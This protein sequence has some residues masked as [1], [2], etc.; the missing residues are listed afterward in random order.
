MGV[1]F[2]IL[3]L[4]AVASAQQPAA[5]TTPH[6]ATQSAAGVERSQGDLLAL[7]QGKSTVI[8]GTISIVDPV[9]D[10]LTLQVFGGRRMKILFDERTEVYR[11]GAK[12]SLRDLHANDRASVET[13]LDG[14][15]VFARSIHML[16][17]SPEGEY[18]G[19]V[20][21]YDPG[22]SILTLSESLTRGSVQLR[23]PA[24]TTIVREG[25]TASASGQAGLSDLVKGTLIAA[26]FQSDKGQGVASRIAIL[27]IPGETLSFS[28]NVS[29]LNLGSNQ[30]VVANA[31]N[32]Q[33]YKISFDPASFPET[34]NLREGTSVKVT[35]EFDGSRY[36]ARTITIQ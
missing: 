33:S 15:D 18:Q 29:F 27:A 23:V 10:E 2:A 17:R 32:D 6:Q 13:M 22:R 7:P 4:G 16:S 26:R 31:G 20:L 36:V 34:R 8:G 12:T 35:A 28:G 9:T 24:G 30:F 3:M 1:F 11:D 25:Q 14:T 21:S 19:Q 5:D